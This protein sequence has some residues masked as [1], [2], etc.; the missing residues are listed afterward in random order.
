VNPAQSVVLV[1]FQVIPGQNIPS[2]FL[3]LYE[4]ATTA[5]K[6]SPAIPGDLFFG[7]GVNDPPRA[8]DDEPAGM[9][10]LQERHAS[11]AQDGFNQAFTGIAVRFR[12]AADQSTGQ[13]VHGWD[14]ASEL[15]NAT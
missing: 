8:A 12:F 10:A 13:E 3:D 5:L 11:E 4:Q 7:L 14:R 9:D 1:R 2:P 6:A 15:P